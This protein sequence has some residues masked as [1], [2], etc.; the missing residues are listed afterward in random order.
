MLNL[1]ELANQSGL[2]LNA[3]ASATDTLTKAGII[4]ERTGQRRNRIF[5]YDAFINI[6]SRGGEPF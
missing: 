1:R 3:A 6:L 5:A 2:S 4:D